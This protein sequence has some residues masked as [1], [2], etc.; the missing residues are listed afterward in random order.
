MTVRLVDCPPGLRARAETVVAG[1]Y[2]D[3]ATVDGDS[4]ADL[5][6]AGLGP[7]RS[8]PQ[9]EDLVGLAGGGRLVVVGDA[10]V[11]GCGAVGVVNA[12]GC[13]EIG[14]RLAPAY[15][16]RGLGTAAVRLLVAALL[17]EPGVR[18]LY[19]DVLPSNEPSGRL[20]ERL[21]FVRDAAADRGGHRRY[22]LRGSPDRRIQITRTRSECS[23]EAG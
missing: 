13:L 14:Y 8:W 6:P 11:G 10:V 16:G 3:P 4:L 21:G 20:L 23:G 19:A 2:A 5:L 1:R 7:G 12:D 17:V 15:Q 9:G 22:V 18:S